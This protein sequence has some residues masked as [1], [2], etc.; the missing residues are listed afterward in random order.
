MK[1]LLLLFIIMISMQASAQ[2]SDEV[3]LLKQQIDS[4]QQRLDETNYVRIPK[5]DFE[6]NLQN[7][8][9]K[10]VSDSIFKWIGFLALLIGL[11]GGFIGAYFKNQIQEQV[12]ANLKAVTDMIDNFKSSEAE[13]NNKQDEKLKELR[14]EFAELKK[15]QEKFIS[16]SE[17]HINKKINQ[18]LSI[19]WDDIADSKMRIA[20][21]KEFKGK[22]LIDEIT[23]LLD[24]KTIE[25]RKEKRVALIDTLM[26]CYYYTPP[27]D[28][29][30]KQMIK[31]LRRYE[32]VTELTLKPE[33]YANAAIALINNYEYYGTKE[34]RETCL[35]CC[36]KSLDRLPDYGLPYAIKLEV[37]MIDFKKAFD[38]K[39]KNAAIENTRR[40][41]N[42]IKNN[43]SRALCHE[44]IS[45]LD[46]D[47]EVPYLKEYIDNLELLFADNL[48]ELRERVCSDI[49]ERNFLD[50]E[51]YKDV[52]YKILDDSLMKTPDIN[53]EWVPYKIIQNGSEVQNEQF[54]AILTFN[55]C[56]YK[57]SSNEW[58]EKG[59]VH[60]L[61]YS[62][63]G[64]INFYRE[65]GTK[66]VM[67]H[68]CIFK[69]EEN[70]Q[71][72]LCFGNS[73]EKRPDEFSSTPS[74]QNIL[75]I[76]NIA[77]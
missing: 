70:N 7:S 56:E 29:N 43:Q 33:T 20:E 45:R 2:K 18:T 66:Y 53:G 52:F 65:E 57:M 40:V 19:M 16:D 27:M 46:I 63:V 36:D 35:D 55:E 64:A 10:A 59:L 11:V 72:M 67:S 31:L 76:Y 12:S 50:D 61:P 15:A 39:D 30:F 47:S 28:E 1:K 69:V 13:I 41:F 74:N 8:V 3:I 32:S 6:K 37:A 38:D 26:R 5:Q 60:F 44:I 25:M 54:S 14:N 62:K 75:V 21:G 22:E 48:L 17:T 23:S 58:D 24:N 34:D 4:L 73:I 42:D 77:A 68:N 51:T 49:V 71:L 9:E